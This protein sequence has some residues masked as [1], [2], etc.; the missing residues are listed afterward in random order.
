MFDDQQQNQVRE[1][2]AKDI[3]KKI[4]EDHLFPSEDEDAVNASPFWHVLTPARVAAARL[5]VTTGEESTNDGREWTDRCEKALGGVTAAKMDTPDNWARTVAHILGTSFV[6][7]SLERLV[8]HSLVASLLGASLNAEKELT[9][10]E[11][12]EVLSKVVQSLERG[13]GFS[14]P[15]LPK[16]DPSG[17]SYF[18]SDAGLISFKSRIYQLQKDFR[19]TLTSESAAQLAKGVGMVDS[20]NAAVK[21]FLGTFGPAWKAFIESQNIVGDQLPFDF[22]VSA[23]WAGHSVLLSVAFETDNDDHGRNFFKVCVYNPGKGTDTA[24]FPMRIRKDGRMQI[25]PYICWTRVPRARMDLESETTIGTVALK[26]SVFS[27][28]FPRAALEWM[29]LLALKHCNSEATHAMDPGDPKDHC[30]QKFYLVL[31]DWLSSTADSSP[32]SDRHLGVEQSATFWITPQRRGVCAYTSKLAYVRHALSGEGDAGLRMYKQAVGRLRQCVAR[33]VTKELL[34]LA[35]GPLSSKNG[36]GALC[37][38]PNDASSGPSAASLATASASSWGRLRDWV[39]GAEEK[40][41][42][43]FRSRLLSCEQRQVERFG[44]L[45]NMVIRNVPKAAKVLWAKYP[46]HLEE[47]DTS[48]QRDGVLPPSPNRRETGA[49]STLAHKMKQEKELL[50]DFSCASLSLAA[51]LQ[52]KQDARMRDYAGHPRLEAAANTAQAVGWKFAIAPVMPVQDKEQRGF[53]TIFPLLGVWVWAE[54]CLKRL[55]ALEAK[56]FPNAVDTLRGAS[57]G[58]QLVLPKR[59]RKKKKQKEMRDARQRVVEPSKKSSEPSAAAARGPEDPHAGGPEMVPKASD[60]EA[61]RDFAQEI[62]RKMLDEVLPKW[63][64]TEVIEGEMSQRPPSV[65]DFHGLAVFALLL[66][67]LLT[68]MMFDPSSDPVSP[69]SLPRAARSD[70]QEIFSDVQTLLRDIFVEHAVPR[71]ALPFFAS[72]I[73]KRSEKLGLRLAPPPAA[74]TERSDKN[75]KEFD[76]FGS[77]EDNQYHFYRR[78]VDSREIAMAATAFPATFAALGDSLNRGSIMMICSKTRRETR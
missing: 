27:P 70:G 25:V 68:H 4:F 20:V 42:H 62:A 30:Q 39:I 60:R 38:A 13:L 22:L 8:D 52:A 1:E 77:R 65:L 45:A 2:V 41:A 11:Q 26:D 43:S 51:I 71:V 75:R 76:G 72:G 36:N 24:G 34:F 23:G 50:R 55:E 18:I 6:T 61:L 33:L 15:V 32:S 12:S 78:E 17:S 29:R 67:K 64:S 63:L 66:Q 57:A 47:E 28:P 48:S 14:G 58:E 16:V 10:P 37:A 54:S 19:L 53:S 9:P 7:G 59:T 21:T 40:G 5:L 56:S 44:T 73:G 31:D 46:D 69:A 3:D 35:V 49:S 74:W